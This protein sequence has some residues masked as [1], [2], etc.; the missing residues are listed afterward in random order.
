MLIETQHI[1]PCYEYRDR[2]P[3]ETPF[4]YGH[5]VANELEAEIQ[6]LGPG[7]V[8][9]FMAE[10]VVGATLGAVGAVEGVG[11]CAPSPAQGR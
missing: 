8:S 7:N 3:D 2:Q 10:P 11:S 4:D 5:R 6:R 1:A 9:C